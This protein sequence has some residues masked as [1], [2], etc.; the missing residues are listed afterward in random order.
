MDGNIRQMLNSIKDLSVAFALDI[1]ELFKNFD[2][3]KDNE[4]SLQEF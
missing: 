1:P 2:S 3:N 4:L